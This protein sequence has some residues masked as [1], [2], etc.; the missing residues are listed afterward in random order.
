MQINMVLMILIKKNCNEKFILYKLPRPAGT[1]SK[2]EG[3]K[4]NFE[5]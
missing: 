5:L 2:F 1:P 4:L 3:D